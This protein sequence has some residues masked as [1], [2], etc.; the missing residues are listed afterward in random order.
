MGAFHN[1]RFPNE[2]DAYRNKRDELLQAE[3]DLR[4]QIEQVA[5]QRREL[6]PGGK[7]KENYVFEEGSAD[8]SDEDTVREVPF[9]ELFEDEKKSLFIYSFM[10]APDNDVPCTSCNSILDGLNGQA[11]HIL[12]RINFAVV[13]KAPIKKLRD[14]AR[15]RGWDNLRLLSSYKNSYNK[16]Y[17]AESE[18]GS[19][20]PAANVFQ[21]TET[22]IH[23]FYNTELLY[24]P[25][26][27]GQN[28]R[29]VDLIWPLWNVFDMTPEGRGSDWY[30]K[31][32][33]NGEKVHR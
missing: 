22:G 17:F 16:D 11:P 20:W 9:S 25:T 32:S 10:Y 14:W 26:E 30:P 6:P 18:D 29:H 24:A 4:K 1:K 19:Q 27:E 5:K 15:K 23:H 28:G 31:F 3:I 2:P 8:L 13:A 21:K 7:I 12:A 33:Y